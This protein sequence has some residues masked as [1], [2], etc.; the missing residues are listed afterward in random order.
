M[1]QRIPQRGLP[2]PPSKHHAKHPVTMRT[3]LFSQV[4]VLP[5][6]LR[7]ISYSVSSYCGTGLVPTGPA[8]LYAVDNFGDLVRVGEIWP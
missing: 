2:R 7:K 4:E 1:T 5:L 3:M 6:G 8:Q